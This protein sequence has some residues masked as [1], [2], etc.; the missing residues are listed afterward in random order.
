[1]SR[2]RSGETVRKVRDDR[3]RKDTRKIKRQMTERLKQRK[4]KKVYIE[5][6]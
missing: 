1:L 5:K 3:E 4:D 6:N 2:R